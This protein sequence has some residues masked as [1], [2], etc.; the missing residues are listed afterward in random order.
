[1]ARLKTKAATAPAAA[2]SAMAPAAVKK[3][4]TQ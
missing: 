3:P 4:P 1:V 2:P